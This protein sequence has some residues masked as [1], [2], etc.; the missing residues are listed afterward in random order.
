MNSNLR[1]LVLDELYAIAYNNILTEDI[2]TVTQTTPKPSN[3]NKTTS[4]TKTASSAKTSKGGAIV[5]DLE[6]QSGVTLDPAKRA[7]QKIAAEKLAA[8]AM[9]CGWG[10]DVEGYKKSGWKCKNTESPFETTAELRDWRTWL[11]TNYPA[12][13]TKLRLPS[14][15]SNETVQDAPMYYKYIDKYAKHQKSQGNATPGL[16]DDGV[17]GSGLTTLQ[18]IG[19]FIATNQVWTGIFGSGFLAT[20]ILAIRGWRKNASKRADRRLNRKT[21][22][23]LEWGGRGLMLDT[24]KIAN[25]ITMSPDKMK[26]ELSSLSNK[27]SNAELREGLAEIT[28]KSPSKITDN[29]LEEVR[30]ALNDPQLVKTAVVEARKM[31]I[32]GYLKGRSGYTADQVIALMSKNERA[33]YEKYVRQLEKRRLKR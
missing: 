10:K 6:K 22:R 21:K 3:T 27:V 7:Q 20:A 12:E 31:I 33:Q 24:A 15:E 32:N 11:K 1:K 17:G 23:W 30:R 16:D 28:G 18:M 4:S 2:G 25:E 13:Y 29:H 8:A 14:L 5:A 9:R 26:S 19:I